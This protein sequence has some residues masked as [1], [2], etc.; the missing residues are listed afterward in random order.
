MGV[1][2][3]ASFMN[4]SSDPRLQAYTAVKQIGKGSYGEVFLV[5]HTREKKQVGDCAQCTHPLTV[6]TG[7][8]CSLLSL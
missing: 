2:A 1:H 4:K 7:S 3:M 5:K 6:M 8:A